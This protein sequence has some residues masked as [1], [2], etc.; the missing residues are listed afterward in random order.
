MH[1]VLCFLWFYMERWVPIFVMPCRGVVYL[2][3]PASLLRGLGL[4]C[5]F[6]FFIILVLYW[7]IPL[8]LCNQEIVRLPILRN[9][10]ILGIYLFI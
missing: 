7:W 1:R 4:M 5:L 3:L 8:L 2:L 6:L 9:L 10:S